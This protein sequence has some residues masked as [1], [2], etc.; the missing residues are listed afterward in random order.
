M[1]KKHD[2]YV[3][4]VGGQGIGLLSEMLIRAADHAGL[5]VKGVDT[6]GLAQ[7]G[8]IVSSHVR[9]GEGAHAPL[10]SGHSADMVIAL[11][12]NEAYRG[13]IEFLAP[14]GTLVYYNTV[15]QPLEV[16][17]GKDEYVTEAMIEQEC[18]L[19]QAKV[20]KVFRNELADAR[21]QNMVLL[22]TVARDGLIEGVMPSHF[23]RALED[24]LEGG[25]LENNKALF[26]AITGGS[27]HEY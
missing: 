14:G 9:I 3:I 19:R 6:H 20:V 11:E 24:L 16:R 18:A 21:M 17:L 1:K 27:P 25:V 7:R 26:T 15:W 23:I 12:R 4:G 22:A 10:I 2:I 8:G 5:Q 13:V